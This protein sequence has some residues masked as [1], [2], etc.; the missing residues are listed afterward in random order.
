[1]QI[2]TTLCVI[3][4]FKDFHVSGLVDKCFIENLNVY[5]FEEQNITADR[6]LYGKFLRVEGCKTVVCRSEPCLPLRDFDLVQHLSGVVQLHVKHVHRWP[7]LPDGNRLEFVLYDSVTP[8]DVFGPCLRIVRLEFQNMNQIPSNSTSGYLRSCTKVEDLRISDTSIVQTHMI[9]KDMPEIQDL[10][11]RKINDI[12]LIDQFP[13]FSKSS[14][15]NLLESITI[16]YIEYTNNTS[17]DI[18][19]TKIST[20][21]TWQ[22][23]LLPKLRKL[24]IE[25]FPEYEMCSPSILPTSFRSLTSLFLYD[26]NTTKVCFKNVATPHLEKVE[27]GKSPFMNVDFGQLF[28]TP[29]PKLQVTMDNV[30]AFKFS[31]REYLSLSDGSR[32]GKITLKGIQLSIDCSCDSE[33][34]WMMR[35][36][37]EGLLVAEDLRCNDNN[38]PLGNQICDRLDCASQVCKSSTCVCCRLGTYDAVAAVCRD[39]NLTQL[40]RELLQM[41]N[42]TQLIVSNNQIFSLPNKLPDNLLRLDLSGNRIKSID[43]DEAT[44]LFEVPTKRVRLA[45]N[46]LIC[47]TESCYNQ[48][49]LDALQFPKNQ[50]EDSVECVGEAKLLGKVPEF[51][52]SKFAQQREMTLTLSVILVVLVAVLALLALYYRQYIKMFLFARGW[53]M[54]WLREEE[55]DGDRRYDVFLSFCH[56]DVQVVL[57]ELLPVLDQ[58][59]IVCVHLRDWVPGEMIPTQILRSVEQSKRTVAVISYNYAKSLWGLLE[60]RTAYGSALAEGRQ[61]VVMI[62]LD[63][64]L[65]S[66]DLNNELKQYITFNTYVR[67]GDPW[68]WSKLRYALP[69]KPKQTARMQLEAQHEI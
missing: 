59:Y 7:S 10:Y 8:L 21:L 61:R 17:L 30:A 24:D 42:L 47:N 60:F 31:R 12:F 27:I 43:A 69:H 53:C 52:E 49:L 34:I 9:L 3:L 45:G 22:L 23:A 11:L 65:E 66:N 68:F 33:A 35:A 18:D 4:L 25:H 40:P 50:V 67:W 51:C 13:L 28:S 20:A 26:T 63:G 37:A 57:E 29:A 32:K 36:M 44:V 62:V 48:P 5:K 64:V 38:K 46:P 54:W 2:L 39:A 1:M 19:W 58:E 41:R 16:S 15:S 14:S 6:F 56:A 55:L